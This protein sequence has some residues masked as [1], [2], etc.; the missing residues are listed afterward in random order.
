MGYRKPQINNVN[1]T[2]RTYLPL[3][4]LLEPE[5]AP[6]LKSQISSIE[7]PQSVNKIDTDEIAIGTN[8]KNGGCTFSYQGKFENVLNLQ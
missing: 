1:M 8:C 6:S 5:I 4:I 2:F 7:Q 3:Q